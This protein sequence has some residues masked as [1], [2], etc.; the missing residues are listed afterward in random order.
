MLAAVSQVAGFVGSD[1]GHNH[2]SN[3]SVYH[4]VAH[5]PTGRIIQTM[6]GPITSTAHD[7]QA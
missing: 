6:S 7:S 5:Q 1:T 3:E 4:Q 2:S